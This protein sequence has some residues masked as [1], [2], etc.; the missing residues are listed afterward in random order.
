[1]SLPAVNGEFEKQVLEMLDRHKALHLPRTEFALRYFV[2]GMH[3]DMCPKTAYQW[4]REGTTCDSELKRMMLELEEADRDIEEWSKRVNDGPQQVID[5]YGNAKFI[6][7]DLQIQKAQNRKTQLELEITGKKREHD[8]IYTLIKEL[9]AWTVEDMEKDEAAYWFGDGEREGRFE[10][11]MRQSWL[12]RN[13]GFDEG[14]L[15][16][17]DQCNRKG[18]GD[19][20]KRFDIRIPDNIKKSLVWSVLSPEDREAIL[21][22]PVTAATFAGIPETQGSQI[23]EG[24][25]E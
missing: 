4:L 21:L 2:G 17:I 12:S 15:M 10:W 13:T 16:S 5:S 22:N 19:D 23:S 14:N 25:S 18:I 9:P 24:S 8:L 1:M 11:Q 6:Y 20:S 3:G 7:P